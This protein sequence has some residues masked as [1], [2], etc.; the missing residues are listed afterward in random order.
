[1]QIAKEYILDAEYLSPERQKTLIDE[2]SLFYVATNTVDEKKVVFCI[3]RISDKNLLTRITKE[4]RSKFA[5]KYASML[6]SFY[7]Q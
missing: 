6:L 3:R 5:K 4:A 2:F 7:S 1:M